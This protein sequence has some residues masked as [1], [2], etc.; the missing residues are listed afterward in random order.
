MAEV[1]VSSPT[2]IVTKEEISYTKEAFPYS[3]KEI[4]D[5]QETVIVST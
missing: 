3:T 2:S 5:S 4:F 1:F